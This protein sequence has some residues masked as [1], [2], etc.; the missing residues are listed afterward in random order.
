MV[1]EVVMMEWWGVKAL[2]RAKQEG[3]AREKMGPQFGP[4][5]VDLSHHLSPQA[6]TIAEDSHAKRS[7]TVNNLSYE[8]SQLN[9]LLRREFEH[10]LALGS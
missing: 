2:E 6:S 9:K 4:S 5:A 1:S 7:R 3:M 10:A 8:I